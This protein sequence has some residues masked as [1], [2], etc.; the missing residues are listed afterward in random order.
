MLL[1]L[2]SASGA[3]CCLRIL[4]VVQFACGAPRSSEH[5]PPFLRRRSCT[6]ALALALALL[7]YAICG[8]RIAPCALLFDSRLTSF[9]GTLLAGA[10]PWFVFCAF[11]CMYCKLRVAYSHVTRYALILALVALQ[12]ALRALEICALC[13]MLGILHLASCALCLALRDL[14]LR[15]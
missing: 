1:A 14:C 3:S 15:S 8:L 7:R 2:R 6:L 10:L 12:F 5:K 9:G 13:V 4:Y 11:Q